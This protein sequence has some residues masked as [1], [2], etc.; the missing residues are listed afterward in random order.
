MRAMASL[1]VSYTHL[2]V[3]KRQALVRLALVSIRL[4][5]APCHIS[6]H[7]NPWQNEQIRSIV[8]VVLIHPKEYRMKQ[9]CQY[10]QG[11][12]RCK[13]NGDGSISTRLP[14][15]YSQLTID[16]KHPKQRQ[17]NGKQQRKGIADD[18]Q[19]PRP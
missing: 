18:G 8:I 16:I 2:D 5:Y 1:S 11:N 3:Y 13:R 10:Q 7:C 4:P 6:K 12:G 15:A 17:Y 9:I 14:I 19:L